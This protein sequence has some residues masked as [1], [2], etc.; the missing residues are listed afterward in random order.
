MQFLE[1]TILSAY[2]LLVLNLQN[3]LQN[4]LNFHKRGINKGKGNHQ[5]LSLCF[6]FSPLA[7]RGGATV[8]KNL[9]RKI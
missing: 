7:T 4:V 6:R 8:T 2:L 5:M 3:K 9:F 1:Q